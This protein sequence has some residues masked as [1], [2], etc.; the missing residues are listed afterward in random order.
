MKKDIYS[1]ILLAGI[2]ILGVKFTNDFWGA[3]IG[4]VGIIVGLLPL[5]LNY[6]LPE[7]GPFTEREPEK[8]LSLQE[9]IN[10]RINDTDGTET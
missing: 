7:R 9:K 8:P 1:N 3:V 10:E 4:L 6:N 2:I 5:I